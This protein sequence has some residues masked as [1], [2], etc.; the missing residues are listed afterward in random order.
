MKTSDLALLAAVGAAAYMLI[1]KSGA[2][3]AVRPIAAPPSMNV[4]SDMWTRILGGAWKQLEGTQTQGGSLSFLKK[5]FG[6]QVTTSD[7]KPIGSGDPIADWINVNTGLNGEVYG[8]EDPF[9]VNDLFGGRDY[10]DPMDGFRNENDY[11]AN[12]R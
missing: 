4:N 5:T 3:G 9:V 2:A 11:F 1:A 10:T 8:G 12:F 7:G 6:G